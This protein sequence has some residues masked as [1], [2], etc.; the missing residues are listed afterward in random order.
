MIS[1]ILESRGS[2]GTPLALRLVIR[3]PLLRWVLSR[4][5]TRFLAIGFRPEH[6]RTSP[7]HNGLVGTP[8][9]MGA[10]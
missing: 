8:P 3:V 4:L 2:A 5:L 9:A 6:V 7:V 1:P 10:L